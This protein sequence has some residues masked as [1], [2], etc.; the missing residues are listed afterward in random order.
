MSTF[1]L[2]KGWSSNLAP[3]TP[4]LEGET[5][6]GADLTSTLFFSLT[7][8]PPARSSWFCVV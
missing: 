1:K 6:E 7:A 5:V 3:S 4:T 2:R 8:L